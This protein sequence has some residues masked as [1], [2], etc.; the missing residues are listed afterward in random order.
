[1]KDLFI[2]LG[3]IIA[4]LAVGALLF[5]YG[6]SSF[7]S[8]F[9]TASPAVSFR[10]LKEG[11]DATGM[12]ERVNYRIT[13][14]SQLNELWGYVEATPGTTPHID[15]TKEDVLAVFDGTHTT[16]GYRIAVTSIADAN[17]TRTVHVT[18]MAPGANCV[19]AS[20]ITAP[21]QIVAVPKSDLKLT[22]VDESVTQDCP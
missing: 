17:G 2:I 7:R 11:N 3:M 18:R 21:Y 14:G 22:H 13:D 15:F 1:M 6:P 4:A 16:T 12:P 5:F 10:L 8:W 9:G 19:T 20:A